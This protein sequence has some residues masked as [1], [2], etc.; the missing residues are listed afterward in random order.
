MLRGAPGGSQML[1]GAPGG[2]LL[3]TVGAPNRE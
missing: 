2:R 3:E 1:R